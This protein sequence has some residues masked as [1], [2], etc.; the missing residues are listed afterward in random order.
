MLNAIAPIGAV[1]LS[2]AAFALPALVP[3]NSIE[4][5]SHGSPKSSHITQIQ[6]RAADLIVRT[7]AV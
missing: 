5:L 7:V 6:Q 3:V 1:S 4:R 2:T